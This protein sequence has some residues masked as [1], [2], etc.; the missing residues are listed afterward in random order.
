MALTYVKDQA[1]SRALRDSSLNADD[2]RKFITQSDLSGS[3]GQ[4]VVILSY[5]RC[6]KVEI[7][8][9]VEQT[10]M[11]EGIE[12][13]SQIHENGGGPFTFVQSCL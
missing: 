4:E 2:V 9:F 7:I 8:Q 6:W 13:R 3:A 11:L 12:C 5:D 1:Q 10:I